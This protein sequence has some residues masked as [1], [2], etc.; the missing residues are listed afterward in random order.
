MSQN[1]IQ[2]FLIKSVDCNVNCCIEHLG[3]DWTVYYGSSAV[4][5]QP[6]VYPIYRPVETRL[7]RRFAYYFLI[8]SLPSHYSWFTCELCFHGWHR[9]PG[10]HVG[11]NFA[12]S[13][14]VINHIY[15]LLIICQTNCSVFLWRRKVVLY[16][17][18]FKT[19]LYSKWG[20][21]FLLKYHALDQSVTAASNLGSICYLI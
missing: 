5:F 13:R 21:H 3:H 7:I 4:A 16:T 8:L 18:N 1:V 15:E 14:N 10:E 9:V 17:P 11:G 19:I 20:L 2:H 6:Q 12:H